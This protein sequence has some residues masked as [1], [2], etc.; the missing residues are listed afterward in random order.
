MKS[1]EVDPF[2]VVVP[3]RSLHPKEVY[4]GWVVIE[5]DHQ[6]SG[7]YV[8]VHQIDEDGRQT[9]HVYDTEVRTPRF[10]LMI[11]HEGVIVFAS[12]QVYDRRPLKVRIVER[13]D[14]LRYDPD[15]T[16]VTKICS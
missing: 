5:V 8:G 16:Q 12:R 13:I 15:L 7:Y 1:I 14:K 11:S 4:V 6:E 10:A 3:A 2:L 9:C